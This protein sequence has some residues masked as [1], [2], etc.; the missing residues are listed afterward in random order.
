MTLNT[1]FGSECQD[2]YFDLNFKKHTPISPLEILERGLLVLNLKN[3][4]I[5]GSKYA[6]SS[7]RPAGEDYL[8][9]VI[10]ME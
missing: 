10:E 3:H 8:F 6:G 1:I 7:N 5:S 2:N 4:P 9:I